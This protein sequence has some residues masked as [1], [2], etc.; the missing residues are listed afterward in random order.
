MDLVAV[1]LPALGV[2]LSGKATK[3]RDVLLGGRPRS[4]ILEVMPDEL[5][6]AHPFAFSYML[7]PFSELLVKR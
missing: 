5:V 3:L 6:Q 7:G 1:E 4:E 2:T